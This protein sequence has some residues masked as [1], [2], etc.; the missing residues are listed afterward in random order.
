ME[1]K[2]EVSW[3]LVI[4]IIAGIILALLIVVACRQEDANKRKLSE[5]H[6]GELAACWNEVQEKG[7]SCRIEYLK[8]RTDTIYAAKVVR[9]VE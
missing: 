4:A 9:E 3:G 8:D 2:S 6:A 7:G 5:L 1:N